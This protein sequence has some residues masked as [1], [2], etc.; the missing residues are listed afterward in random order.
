MASE[1]SPNDPRDLWQGQEVEKMTLTVDEVRCRSV[2]FERR[3][4]WRNVREYT[5]G[6]LVVSFYSAQF[7]GAHGWRLAPAALTIAGTVYVMFQLYRRAGARSLPEDMGLRGSI[8]FH[9]MELERQRNALEAVWRWYLM[10]FVPGLAAGLVVTG[11]DHGVSATLVRVGVFILTVFVG[12]WGLN[13][14][15][16][17]KLDRRIQE[18]K[19][20][21]N[22]AE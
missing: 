17:R 6:A 11:I 21:E 4:H 9:R 22:D 10:P 3:V 7:R 13:K 1:M 14:R 18:L 19:A 12:I 2:R 5:A 20:M 16:A 15:G 8:E